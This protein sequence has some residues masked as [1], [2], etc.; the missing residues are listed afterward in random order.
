MKKSATIVFIRC[1]AGTGNTEHRIQ[2]TEGRREKDKSLDH[3]C[4]DR[5]AF[6]LPAH[7]FILRSPFFI[8]SSSFHVFILYS[9]FYILYSPFPPF[10]MMKEGNY[11]FQR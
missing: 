10:I 8:L 6:P 4:R 1:R 2:E 5:Q 7:I 9:V 11:R 3:E